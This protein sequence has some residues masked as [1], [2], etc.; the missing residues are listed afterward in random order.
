MTIKMR[1]NE[2]NMWKMFNL[3]DRIVLIFQVGDNP[4]KHHLQKLGNSLDRLI[5]QVLKVIA[6]IYLIQ[7]LPMARIYHIQ[8]NALPMIVVSLQTTALAGRDPLLS[9]N[10]A[11]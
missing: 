2:G 4:R 10:G 1:I 7:K 3:N 6:H 8:T 11:I 5:F 9:K